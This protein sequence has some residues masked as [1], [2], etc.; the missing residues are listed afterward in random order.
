[1]NRQITATLAAPSMTLP[2]A[3]PTSAVD[4]ERYPATSPIAPSAVIHANDNAESISTR[5]SPEDG[6]L[7]TDTATNPG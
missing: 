7:S 1:V 3:Q 6:R 4:P 5:R 2:N